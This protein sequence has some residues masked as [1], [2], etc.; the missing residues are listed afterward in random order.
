M[1]EQN[2]QGIHV[3]GVE[4]SDFHRIRVARLE[5]VPGEGLVRVTGKNGAGKTSLLR[6]VRA[7]LGGAGEMLPASIREGAEDGAL[8]RL[9]LSNGFTVTRRSTPA[10]PK[11]YLT[12][13][14][15]DGGKHAQRKLNEWLG[16]HS[17]DPLAF[18]DLPDARQG[19]ILMNL[20]DDPNLSGRLEELR[21][22]HQALYNER[23]PHISD[24]RRCRAVPKPEGERPKPVDTAGEMKRLAELQTLQREQEEEQRALKSLQDTIADCDRR[25]TETR[26][27]LEA[28]EARRSEFVEEQAA[29]EQAYHSHT[30]MTPEV[31]AVTARISEADAVNA[32]LEPWKRWDEAQT[33]LQAAVD[34]VQR[35]THAMK[36][37]E[38][39]Q[40]SL[41]EEA[42]IPVPGVTF[43]DGRP[44]LNG[45][46]LQVASG[47]ERIR[48]AVSV[49]LAV[50]PQLRICLVDEANDL[51][52]ESME[53]LDGLAREHDFQ[54]WACRIGLEGPGEV[55]VEDG[56]ARV[57]EEA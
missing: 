10:N 57:P 5:Y 25:I 6:A 34:E 22:E 46:P 12:V 7:A 49:A 36:D 2:G 17:F 15:P 18:F 44:L 21:A 48:M 30:D 32:S 38:A 9:T 20:G 1:T 35:L 42:G 11:G 37:L 24:E 13:E 26:A 28:L 50:D 45:R 52:P 39:K 53:E 31:E 54:I 56:E 4:V 8:I 16:P 51:D 43:E 3:V 33:A 27:Q 41:V 55:I 19:E 29:L 40:R 47:G 14:G 23:T